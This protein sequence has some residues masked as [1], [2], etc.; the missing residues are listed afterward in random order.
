MPTNDPL[1]N[2]GWYK[3][4]KKRSKPAG[5][6]RVRRKKKGI[7]TGDMLAVQQA[8]LMLREIQKS[9]VVG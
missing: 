4:I 9:T 7:E 8:E 1:S 2:V 5:K 6:Q 3:H